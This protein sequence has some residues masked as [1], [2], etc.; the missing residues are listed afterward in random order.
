MV[1]SLPPQ[2][3]V[4]EADIDMIKRSSTKYTVVITGIVLFVGYL[5]VRPKLPSISIT[6][7]HLD[8]FY[9]DQASVLTTQLTIVVKFK[10]DNTKAHVSFSKAAFILGFHGVE[11]AELASEPFEVKKN[12]SVEFNY[13]VESTPIP[14]EPQIGDIADRSI[15]NNSIMFNLKGTARTGWRVIE[16]V[17]SVKFWLHLNCDLRFSLDGNIR[18]LHCSNKSK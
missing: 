13:Q 14:L 11:I 10:N 6:A 16:V 17:R 2:I 18:D 12:S 4:I 8:R 1:P 5:V 15:K 7:A 9:Y 3:A